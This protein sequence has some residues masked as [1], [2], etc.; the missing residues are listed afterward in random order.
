MFISEKKSG[1]AVSPFEAKKRS[2]SGRT[3]V[4]GWHRGWRPR[5]FV[6]ALENCPL[7]LQAARSQQRRNSWLLFITLSCILS[8]DNMCYATLW[9][10]VETWEVCIRGSRNTG[11]LDCLWSVV[12]LSGRHWGCLHLS[13]FL[14]CWWRQGELVDRD[15]VVSSLWPS[16]PSMTMYFTHSQ[17]CWLLSAAL[18]SPL[19]CLPSG[20][21]RWL[22]EHNPHLDAVQ[23]P[24][25]PSISV[26]LGNVSMTERSVSAGS[27][28]SGC[29][30]PTHVSCKS[31][32]FRYLTGPGNL[33]GAAWGQGAGQVQKGLVLLAFLL[34]FFHLE[35]T[36]GVCR[37]GSPAGV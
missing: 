37:E 9:E 12:D 6:I 14:L 28:Q 8:W 15:Q 18:R 7:H 26:G 27:A 33:A 29:L 5:E 10:S 11:V 17:R 21:S 13:N 2:S 25:V 19:P 34:W 4:V 30:P 36:P 31:Q 23:T 24:D 20:L 32:A 16:G 22:C 3:G 35:E 1:K